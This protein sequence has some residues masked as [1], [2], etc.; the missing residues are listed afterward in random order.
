MANRNENVPS[1]AWADFA[2]SGRVEDYLRYR[3]AENRADA[4]TGVS[5]GSI[6]YANSRAGAA[7][8]RNQRRRP[9]DYGAY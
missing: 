1:Q 4:A 2:A 8:R 9:P 3:A 5:G 6:S 7:R